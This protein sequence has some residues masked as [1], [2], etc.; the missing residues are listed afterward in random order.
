MK[1]SKLTRRYAKWLYRFIDRYDW[2]AS[3]LDGTNYHRNCENWEITDG[4]FPPQKLTQ[5]DIQQHL[6]RT[7]QLHYLSLKSAETIL[8]TLDFDQHHGEGDALDNAMYV[9]EHYLPH[10]FLES[11]PHG[12]RLFFLLYIENV[13]RAKINEYLA[14]LQVQLGIVTAAAGFK[15]PVEVM[16][17]YTVEDGTGELNRGQTAS[18]PMLWHGDSDMDRLEALPELFAATAFKSIYNDATAVTEA[19]AAGSLL[20]SLYVYGAWSSQA[21]TIPGTFRT[22]KNSDAFDRMMKCTHDYTAIHHRM[23]DEEQLLEQYAQLY[24]PVESDDHEQRRRRRATAA[25]KRR[26]KIFDES[27][28]AEAGY[29][30]AKPALMEAV[31]KYATD[32]TCTYKAEITDEDLAIGLYLIQ[33]NSFA[34]NDSP[35]TQW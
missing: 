23:P 32:R 16:G 17:G 6:K 24:G 11:T 28:A 18:L 14:D 1:Y 10:T 34:V 19:P 3:S 12:C 26:A 7:A 21:P 13:R 4:R 33:R 5:T 27:K 30:A 25:I 9:Q 22:V 8:I 31:A 35:R 15:S 2:A 29:E 20:H